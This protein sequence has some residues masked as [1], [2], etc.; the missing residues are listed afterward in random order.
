M[1][2]FDRLTRAF[3]GTAREATP[4]GSVPDVLEEGSREGLA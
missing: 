4:A 1:S 2:M 3:P